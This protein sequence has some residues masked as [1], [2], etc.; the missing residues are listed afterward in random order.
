MAKL[1]P[2][3]TRKDFQNQ[4]DFEEAMGFWQSRV[5]RIQAMAYMAQTRALSQSQSS[6]PATTESLSSVKPNTPE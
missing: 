2:P 1:P 6:T 5:G 3:P 4:E